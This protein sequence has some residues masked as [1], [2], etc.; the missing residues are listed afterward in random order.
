MTLAFYESKLG[1]QNEAEEDITQATSRGASDVESEFTKA[2][3]YAVLGQRDRAL[4]LVLDCLKRGLSEVEVDLAVDL[5][6]I[7]SDP[8]FRRCL[9]DQ[10]RCGKKN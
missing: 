8:D 2:Q 3:A 10:A 4:R 7:R 6:E 5:R 9:T 1:H